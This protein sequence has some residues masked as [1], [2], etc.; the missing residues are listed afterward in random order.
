MHLLSRFQRWSIGIYIGDSPFTLRNPANIPNPV[1]TA[2]DVSDLNAQFVADPFIIRRGESWYMLF[3]AL[4]AI[5]GRGK[6]ACARSYDGIAWSY[7]RI[8]LEEPFHLSY[9]YVFAW[10]DCVYMVPESYQANAVRLYRANEFPGRWELVG[11][12]LTGRPFLDSSLLYHGSQWWLFSA[13][14]LRND[15]LRL[16]FAERVEGPWQEHPKSPLVESNAHLARPGGR[17]L[18]YQGRLFRFAQ[19]DFKGY[20]R[21]VWA[22]EITR[23]NATDYSEH[24]YPAEPLLRRSGCSL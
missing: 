1:L 20:G 5:S 9:P 3:E 15:R 14:S 4:D 13:D 10:Q 11:E 22:M 2:N 6:I 23:L 7:D 18:E 12:L 21:H 8:V 16:Y 17:L 19:D 24:P